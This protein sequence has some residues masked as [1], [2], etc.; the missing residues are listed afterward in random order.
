MRIICQRP[1]FTG[2]GINLINLTKK[3]VQNDIDQCIIFGQPAGETNPFEDIIDLK[4][5]FP[6]LFY[7]EQS[8]EKEP[9]LDRKMEEIEFKF[10]VDW[11]KTAFYYGLDVHKYELDVAIYS[12]DDSGSDFLKTNVFSVDSKGLKSFWRFVES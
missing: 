11:T 6:V 3:T 12:R 4:W 2:S 10:S 8:A 5:T 1:Y 9:S 7:D